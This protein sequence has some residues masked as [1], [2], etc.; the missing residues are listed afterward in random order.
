MKVNELISVMDD[1]L[2]KAGLERRRI[3]PREAKVWALPSGEIERFF[4]PQ[5]IR[6]PW[7]FAYVGA[8]GIEIP[9]L[10]QWL[11]TY[12]REEE[13]GI[14]RS[15]FVLS[16][17]ANEDILGNF[18]IEHGEPVPSDVW[19]GLLTDRLSN[20]PA[21]MDELI[22]AYQRRSKVLGSLVNPHDQH[23][24]EFLLAWRNDPDPSMHV[25]SRRPDGRVS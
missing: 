2:Q 21:T 12:K 22:D 9:A 7:G 11:A 23:A 18:M 4:W 16:L 3:V 20:V 15:C 1:A 5:A 24:W 14:F 8:I 25:P 10:R 17:I 13:R 19:A 6:R